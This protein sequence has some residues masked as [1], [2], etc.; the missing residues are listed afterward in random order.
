MHRI[1]TPAGQEFYLFEPSHW[2]GGGSGRYYPMQPGRAALLDLVDWPSQYLFLFFLAFGFGSDRWPEWVFL[3]VTVLMSV[4]GA[5]LIKGVIWLLLLRTP[6][7][8]LTT[9]EVRS[10]DASKMPFFKT[11]LLL[12]LYL[13]ASVVV[14]ALVLKGYGTLVLA[15]GSILLA[16]VLLVKGIASSGARGNHQF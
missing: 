11:V 1:I 6:P 5:V 2:F 8:E 12:V 14:G 4:A 16:S 9:E 15:I 13:G 10:W 3:T 7:I